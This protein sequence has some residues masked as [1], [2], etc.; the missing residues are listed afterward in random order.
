MTEPA[1]DAA[2]FVWASLAVVAAGMALELWLL[3]RG[4]SR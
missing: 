1:T 4:G 2:L 3:R